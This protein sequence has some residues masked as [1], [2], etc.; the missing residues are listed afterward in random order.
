[1]TDVFTKEKRSEVMSKIK[2]KNTKIEL[3][4]RSW[5]HSQGYRYRLHDKR[6]PGTPD[7]VLP[8]YKTAIFIH[9]CFW[10]AHKNCK[11]F[12]LPMTR[13]DFWSEKLDH[14]V[15]RDQ[16]KTE[17]LQLLGWNVIVVWECELKHNSNERLIKLLSEIM[18]NG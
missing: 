14:N 5:L 17:E 12:K 13:T 9:G 1:M 10:H 3:V 2:G 15:V 16:K 7:V 8:K 4:V 18:G 11:Y 6:F